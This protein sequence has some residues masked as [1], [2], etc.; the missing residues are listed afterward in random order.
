MAT[1]ET[2]DTRMTRRNVSTPLNSMPKTPNR[3]AIFRV[4]EK[5]E[6]S[7]CMVAPRGRTIS[8]MSREMPL[9]SAAS[10]LAGIVA[11]E[12]QVPSDVTAGF[13][14]WRNITPGPAAPPPI[15]AMRGKAVRM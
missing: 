2:T 10:M 11:M 8:V 4:Q 5:Q 9:S 3:K 15:Q 14:M 6:P 13:R 7:M 12:E 1:E